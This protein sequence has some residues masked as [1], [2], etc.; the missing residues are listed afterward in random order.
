MIENNINKKRIKILIII[1]FIVGAYLLSG[2]IWIQ[3]VKGQEYAKK[4]V[5]NSLR[6]LSIPATRGNIYDVNG[7]VLVNS[8]SG[9][10]VNVTYV[11]KEQNE[12]IVNIIANLILDKRLEEDFLIQNEYENIEGHNEE[13]Q[14]FVKAN[15]EETLKVLKESIHEIIESQRF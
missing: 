3:L 2:L 6:F 1:V 15:K 5:Y 4:A 14:E 9:Y 11:S 8:T 12:K 13:Y 7:E 10:T